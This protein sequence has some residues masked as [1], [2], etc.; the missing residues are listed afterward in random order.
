VQR[1]LV[2]LLAAL[3]RLQAEACGRP[4]AHKLKNVA[5]ADAAGALAK[6]FEHKQL[7]GRDTFDAATN[8]VY[9]SAEPEAL[10]LTRG[11]LAALDKQ[12]P[13]VV[14][15]VVVMRV[16]KD[17]VEQSGLNV[18]AAPD[19]NVWV[20]TEREGYMFN[21]FM[22]EAKA[23]GELDVFSRPTL[24]VGDNQTGSVQIGQALPLVGGPAP[25]YVP[26]G[27]TFRATPRVSP[28]GRILLRTEVQFSE[29]VRTALTTTVPGVPFPITQ[30]VQRFD[31]RSAQRTAECK[32]GETIVTRVGETLVLITAT[33]AK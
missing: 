24:A 15:Q 11:L 32:S 20:L 10:L 3:K 21:A 18:G 8:T 5:A 31:T 4:H 33:V 12:P 28:D 16:S 27:V 9:V 17:F 6:H 13:L 14:M 1:V 26:L 29:L 25:V 22:R 19:T 23:R 7:T 2:D 30:F